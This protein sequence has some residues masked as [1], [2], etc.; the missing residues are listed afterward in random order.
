VQQEG[1]AS[2]RPKPPE[3]PVRFAAVTLPVPA[4]GGLEVQLP[5]GAIARGPNAV[6]LA[7]LIRGLHA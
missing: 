5:C 1:K 6:E 7:Q 2:G 3:A 4:P